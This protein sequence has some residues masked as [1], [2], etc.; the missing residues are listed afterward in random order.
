M[1]AHMLA[2]GGSGV[3]A[4]EV[5]P[6]GEVAVRGATMI[7]I[8]LVPSRVRCDVRGTDPAPCLATMEAV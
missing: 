1:Q 7:E 4:K 5:I 8:C 2:G 3:M 6:L